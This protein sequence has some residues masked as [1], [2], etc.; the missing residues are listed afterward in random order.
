[1]Q[2]A[3]NASADLL[4]ELPNEDNNIVF[5]LASA[6]ICQLTAIREYGRKSLKLAPHVFF[7]S[8]TSTYRAAEVMNTSTCRTHSSRMKN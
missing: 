3:V 2:T 4:S 1:M 6:T 7:V 8:L 5:M